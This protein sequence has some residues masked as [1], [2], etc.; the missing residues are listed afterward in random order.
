MDMIKSMRNM[1]YLM[2]LMGIVQ[3]VS[4]CFFNSIPERKNNEPQ[5][6]AL[7]IGGGVTE[8]DNFESFYKNIEYV[9]NTLIKLGYWDED[10]KILFYGGKTPNHPVVEGNAT[11]E[12][13][14]DELSDL[15]HTVDSNDSLVIFRSGHGI[16]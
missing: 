14:I 11:K 10:I 15:G 2:L 4:F 3:I 16:M 8:G 12:N 9:S 13:F 5:K 1:V 6:Y 7:L